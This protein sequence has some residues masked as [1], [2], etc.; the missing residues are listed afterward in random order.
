ML[1]KAQQN[2]PSTMVIPP[3]PLVAASTGL[4]NMIKQC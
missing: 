1:I 3:A 4:E 2:A